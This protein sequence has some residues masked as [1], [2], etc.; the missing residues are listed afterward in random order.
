M[1]QPEKFEHY[2][3]LKNQDGTFAEL[4]HGAMGVTYKAFDTNLR[5]NVALKV[6]IG[7]HLNDPTARERFL[8][9]ARGAAQLRHR[10]VASVFHLGT[11]GESYFYAMEFIEGENVD[12]RVKREG[13]IEVSLAIDIASQVAAALIAAVKQGLV[14][15]DIKPSNLMLI[16]EDDGEMIVKVI[17][18]GL[19]KS[20]FVGST[21]GALTSTGFVG[22][23][24]Y[25]SPEQLDQR[26]EDIRSDI[27]SLGVTLW[28]MLTGKPTFMGSVAS[29]IAQHLDKPPAFEE[30]AVL[31]TCVVEVL[32]RMLEKDAESR[33]QSPQELR[34]ELKRCI[35]ILAEAGRAPDSQP[36][37]MTFDQAS[38]T[39]GLTAAPAP[40]PQPRPGSV[41]NSRYQLIE[42]LDPTKPG[43]TFH[44]EDVTQKRR[45]RVK[46]A[47]CSAEA[48]AMV[49]DQAEKAQR[50]ANANFV[51]VLATERTG[52]W[53]YAVSEWLEG[54]SLCALLRARRELNLRE[55]LTLLGQIAPPVDA[56]R[57]L[58]VRLSLEL[59]DVLI[60]FPE[61]FDE[62]DEQLLLRCPIA[63]WPAFVVKL[64]PLG[65]LDEVDELNAAGDRTMVGN[66]PASPPAAVSQLASIAYELLGGRPGASGPLAN[67][68]EQGN[69]LLRRALKDGEN[70]PSAKA[71]VTQFGE[72][73]ADATQR[74]TQAMSVQDPVAAAASVPVPRVA[75]SQGMKKPVL[76]AA[77]PPPASAR[78]LPAR[79]GAA[80]ARGRWKRDPRLLFGMV[81]GGVLLL[82]AAIF[83]FSGDTGT[84]GNPAHTPA[85]SNGAT[86]A[87]VVQRQPP[88]PGKPWKNI[89]GMTYVPVGDVWFAAAK[90]RVRDFQTYVQETNYDAVGGM[91][92]L[93]KDGLKDHGQSWKDPGFKQTPDDPVVGI[94]RE[95]ANYFCKWLTDKERAAGALNGAQFYR[96]PTDRE[97]SEAVGL[98]NET[99]ATP[100]ERS[101]RIKGVYPWGRGFP[102][103]PEAGNYAGAEAKAGAPENWPVIPAYHDAFP[104]T[105]PVT[106]FP[107]NQRGISGLGGNVWEWCL[108][109]YGRTNPRWGVLR[110]GSWATSR[111]DELLSS[112]RRN[113]D[114]SF[115]EDDVG[116]RCV[117]ASDAGSR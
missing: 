37:T 98:P 104:R 94:S 48:F 101:G 109:S 70:F 73:S 4:G 79:D 61:G 62:A 65:S 66:R 31:P 25:A 53:G 78:V 29:V 100:E 16:R 19:V 107:I 47:Q 35:E 57:T 76:P 86:A 20:A 27:Y 93:G 115:R 106:S 59:H 24:Y 85:A 23:P 13:P 68:P 51:A 50:A 83:I 38:Q 45:V 32:R 90:T 77:P 87:P 54:F 39:I 69:T 21:A 6:I 42:D 33:I 17:D 80:T 60:H 56:A 9:E 99:G 41:L 88:Q 110:G 7:A 22:T 12:A 10:N 71:F 11:C 112:Y 116:F 67:V 5:C 15:R 102:P 18:F 46:L 92:S 97:W 40:Q 8:R 30:L 117:I 81:G 111:P 91:Y 103:P 75:S 82:I 108:D 3:L 26:S 43:R 44:A 95:D 89:L 113:Y 14:H 96:L 36:A 105:G 72:A 28:F 49:R 34:V 52:S 74:P 55:T 58:G 84:S 63:E 1:P 2:E 114:P 64:D